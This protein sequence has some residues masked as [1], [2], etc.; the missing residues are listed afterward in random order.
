M[1]ESA[2]YMVPRG[3]RDFPPEV[4]ILRRKVIR[5]IEEIFERYGFDPFET[6]VIEY[7][8]TLRGKYGE[9][10]E[11][12]LLYRFQDPWSGEWLAL[13]Y[14][15]TVPLARFIAS[16]LPTLPF[17]RYHIGRVWRHERPQKGRY[18]EFWQCDADIVGSP[19]PEADA[20]VV[21]VACEVMS[22]LGYKSFKVRLNDRRLLRGVFEEEF[23]LSRY[24]EDK[25]LEAFRIIDKLEKIGREAVEGELLRSGLKES[26]V[27]GIMEV[28]AVSGNPEGTLDE[29]D[30]RFGEN[31]NVKVAIS[32]LQ[33]LLDAS[34]HKRFLILDLSMV[35]GLDYYT[36]PIFEVYVDEPKI[37]ALA[38]G[39]RYDDL[40]E[41]Y[42]GPSTPSTGV[43][44][45]LE[46]VIDAALELGLLSMD[47][48]TVTEVF[49]VSMDDEYRSYARKVAE[50]M[51]QEGIPVQVDL[52]NRNY[53][54]QLDYCEKKGIRKLVFVGEQEAST[55]TV[56]LYFKDEKRRYEQIP[57]QEAIKIINAN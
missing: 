50:E 44:I 48:K 49:V 14:D 40:I 15:L 4:A 9:E 5:I 31:E 42:G 11:S 23:H 7:W 47:R 10:V 30:R 27:K 24:G 18:R 20:E 36:G 35:R 56:T 55:G 2:K 25:V 43:S 21:D 8:D 33:G 26:E 46:R 28:V 37:G 17:K 3:F 39:G 57:I 54:K 45:G 29:L 32:H 41:R 34:S 12:K 51:R 52:M 38:G 19:Y 16:H 53:K 22:T 13:R 6:P 1:F